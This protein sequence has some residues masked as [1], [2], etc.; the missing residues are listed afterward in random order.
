MGLSIKFGRRAKSDKQRLNMMRRSALFLFVTL[1][2][3]GLA[4]PGLS[5]SLLMKS[6]SSNKV[7]YQKV[8]A[9]NSVEP[10]KRV[11]LNESLASTDL[12]IKTDRTPL[13]EIE[14]LR[15]NNSST[16]LN[17]DG[18]KT[19][20][21]STSQLNFKEGKDWKKISNSLQT[22]STDPVNF[23]EG[24]SNTI[25]NK[26]PRTKS[27]RGDAGII[28][29]TMNPLS[30]GLTLKFENRE[31]VVRPNGANDVYPVKEG[32]NTIVYENAWPNVDLKYELRG[33]IVKELI[34]VKN[35][36]AR[37]SFDFTVSGGKLLNHP[38]RAGEL[39]IEGVDP[40]AFSFSSLTL[41]V[42]ERGVISEPRVSQNPTK[43]G[44]RVTLDDDWV[45]EQAADAFP[46]IIDPSF[47]RY[48]DVGMMYKSDGFSCNQTNCHFNTGM[49]N[50][51][52]GWKSWR[53]E[54]T[55]NYQQAMGKR[56]LQ[57]QIDMPIKQGINRAPETRNLFATWAPCMGFN[58]VGSGPT[59]QGWADADW[60]HID[61]KDLLQ[62]A[63]NAN[64]QNAQFLLRGEEPGYKTYKP[65]YEMNIN[66]VYDTPSPVSQ[67]VEPADKQ[68][69]VD[70]QPTLKGTPITDADGT[71][72]YYFRVTTNNDGNTGA[73][74][75]SGWVYSP[76]WTVPDGVL[77]DGTTYYWK[78]F[79]KDDTQTGTTTESPVRSFKVN[80]RTGKDSTQSYDTVGPVG[81][82]LAT[83]NGSMSQDTHSMTAL[84]GSIGLN[85]NYNTPNKAKKGLLGEY[86]NVPTNYNPTNGAPKDAFG[87]EQ[88]PSVKRREQSVD[89]N[90]GV[91]S[92]DSAIQN[93]G[94]FARWTGQFV[95]P[96]NGTYQ[97]GGNN[98][99][100]MRVW[101]NGTEMYN[102]GCYTGVCYDN[103]KNIQLTAGQ[104]VPMK[105]EYM[106]A[107][108]VAYAR[109]YVKGPVTEQIV[110][111]NWLYANP[112]N[113]SSSY[114]LNGRY[115][116][117]TGDHNIDTA[118][119]DPSRL[120][121]VR[122]DTKLNINYG[123]GGPAQG[124]QADNF[125]TRWT[126]FINVP[127]DGSYTLGVV[128]DDGVRIKL[129]NG[130]GQTPNT[131]L[132]S[133]SYTGMS[134]R[135]G[136][137]AN[138]TAANA[139]PITIDYSEISG[140]ASIQL[141][142]RM[143]NGTESEVPISW[144]TPKA[145]ALP[146]QWSLG[147]DVDGN[148]GYERMRVSA[149][150]AILEDSTGSTH[151]YTYV[152]GGYKPPVNEDG[153][154][155]RN[156]DNTYTL[157]DTDGR[158]YIFNAEGK[159]KSL[160]TPS[161]DRSPASLKYEYSENPS[162][163]TKITDGVTSTRYGTLHY[164]G[165][166]EDGK[167]TVDGGFAAA[168]NG[169]LCA[170]STSDGDVTKLRY[171]NS[172]QLTRVE[173]PG[174]E[175][176]DYSYDALG[177]IV[178]V[179]DSMANDAIAASSTGSTDP[180]NMV[181]NVTYDALSRVSAVKA[182]AASLGAAR[183][184]HTMDYLVGA[185][186]L[187]IAG[188]SE[189]HGFSKRVEYDGL[190]RTTK[191]TD[192]SNLSSFT[193]W[194]PIKDLKRSATDAT[195]LKSTTVYDDNDRA[196]ENYGPAPSAWYDTNWKPLASY[197]NQ[198][199]KTS[200][201]YDEGM[202]G[203]AVNYLEYGTGSKSLIGAS[204][205]VATNISPNPA[206]IARNFGSNPTDL[207]LSTNWGMR[208]TGK[209]KLPTA[210][211]WSFR[212]FSDN[213]VRVWIDDQIVLEDWTDG[214][215]RSHT[216]FS[217]NNTVANSFHRI[218]V[219]YYHTTGD[220]NFALYAT[221]P[222]GTETANVAQ[223]FGPD[224]M[225]A[226]S[227]TAYDAQLGNVT[228]TTT[229]SKPEYGL[230]SK[231]SVDPTGLNLETQ[232]TYEAPGSGFLRQ[233][234][235]TLPGGSTTIYQYYGATE[236][237]VNPCTPSGTPDHQGGRPKGKIEADP[238]GNGP[239]TGRSSE[240]VY[241]KSG[242]IVA[243][244][245]NADPWTCINY[246]SRGRVQS[247][248]V[249]Q[250]SQYQPART[251]ANNYAAGGNPLVTSTTDSTG[252]ITVE[253]DLLGRTV[254]YT[255]TKGNV[256]TNAY[257]LTGLLT[258]RSSPLGTETF[259][260][261]QYD[262]L[263]DQ[264]LDGTT[265]AHIN[266]DQ[267]GRTDNVTYPAAGQ[268][269]VQ[270]SRDVLG[271]TNG[272]SY[273]TVA[274]SGPGPNLVN[275]SSLEQS[276]G[277]PSKPVSWSTDAWGNNTSNLTYENDAHS[278]GKSIKA[279]ITSRTDGDAKWL[280]DSVSVAAGT[281]YTYTD[282]YKSTAWT[283]V[284]AK[285]T[286]Q[287]NS[288]SWVWLGGN[289]ASSSWTQG[290]YSFTTPANAVKVSVTRLID[291]VGW[292][293]LDDVDL[294]QISGGSSA[295]TIAD[296]VAYAV[297]GDVVSGTENGM[298]KSYTYDKG[299]RLTNATI[300]SNSFSYEFGT[301]DA[302]CS[303][304]AGN[305]TNAGKSGNRTKR[306]MN[307]QV[308]TYCYDNAD[309]IIGSSDSAANVFNYDSHGN[310]T[311]INATLKPVYD[312]SDRN[313]G[314]EEYDST[315]NGH[316]VYYVRDAQDRITERRL[317][318][319][320]N[321]NWQDKGALSYGFTGSGD[322]P[323]FTTNGAGVVQEKYLTLPGDVVLTI[324]P[325]QSGS[326]QKTY[327]LPNIHDDVFATTN[328]D[329]VL[330][331]THATGPFGEVLPSQ[332][333]PNNTTSGTT[334]NYVGQHEKITETTFT[335]QL[336]QMGARVYVPNLGRFLSVDPVEG[337]VDNNYV[338]PTDPVNNYDLTGKAKK[339]RVPRS[340]NKFNG[341]SQREL[342]AFE[343]KRIG[344]DFNRS[345]YKS[346]KAKIK[347]TEKFEQKRNVQK[348]VNNNKVSPKSIPKGGSATPPSPS[349]MLIIIVLPPSLMKTLQSGYTESGPA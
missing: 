183:M 139:I 305:N 199:P 27:F 221:P 53:S 241:N 180:D 308:T 219:D 104:V 289:N 39:A 216:N 263:T 245:Y 126:G 77:Q 312:A 29:A 339:G 272:Q 63:V 171:N 295:T 48:N 302:S 176:T 146:D 18:S 318:D 212:I 138:L 32:D 257:S 209:M 89:F 47:Y 274:A 254:K 33:E 264:K 270:Y 224:Y 193:E 206:E 95:A 222:S 234:S 311:Q 83:G 214:A 125:M 87:N 332:L 136:T 278:G 68:V 37:T 188:S 23:F 3:F 130:P 127:T 49:L 236:S 225:L 310:T 197:A 177:R 103:T 215:Q 20:K 337:G 6:L 279:E 239:Q 52:A 73:V 11:A 333:N 298:A 101:V 275:N 61:I 81:I 88:T 322:T 75:N 117:D 155:A 338:Y 317:N 24:I 243:T 320:V 80:L 114:G 349:P 72:Q 168:P 280:F 134:T 42:N 306:T 141:L 154:L 330:T 54:F 294:H 299:G 296:S 213:G 179:R 307:G 347:K 267:F 246:D 186:Q 35:K 223:Y 194:D 325:G 170:F 46:M 291:S 202:T 229:Y 62:N 70:T 112:I 74:I 321:W 107:T 40:G 277:S 345:D 255:D 64:E 149:N 69:T 79:T 28:S 283:N 242:D 341:L 327:S 9:L 240:T 108:S 120:M 228:S 342:K 195:G 300:G 144:L 58:C 118:A 57:A 316:A 344:G 286:L 71:A 287:D 85:F 16:F 124:L 336:I 288:V 189:P 161:D 233:T 217:Y 51:G 260:Y 99:D 252:T 271:R 25:T 196:I 31:I 145:N 158:T 178:T 22:D 303:G 200:T 319:I 249:P 348:R 150:S 226:T 182:P 261:D 250:L 97:F 143:P 109:L 230:V 220:A 10:T 5:L 41:D 343:L 335:N 204:K 121:M 162:R 93:D 82:D 36:N 290:S 4:E 164:A 115:Y 329:G 269:K 148:I 238:D 94:Y 282:Y 78:I 15:T 262:R 26:K 160:T 227:Q 140:P 44:L 218:R 237:R 314:I 251:I 166:N 135:W 92:P 14:N 190:L 86:W 59:A 281:N 301:S 105:V 304:L 102:Q 201:A 98:D 235:K 19:L 198:V 169:M 128:A 253:N 90:W 276:S 129:H 259:V 328:A 111:N 297:S 185:T 96:T 187:H 7:D 1:L 100:L 326:A 315:G 313:R 2:V 12:K 231:T 132:D 13:K 181:T 56:I 232:A 208:M 258:S 157:L 256:T 30:E 211:N 43:N 159:L 340:T 34:V 268:Q 133:W 334:F 147:V 346:A 323:D 207:G 273:T 265:Y 151:E 60:G 173:K 137:S 248:S 192:V 55:F 175:M 244:R 266:Y 210:G 309:R 106:E 285:Y 67:Q 284:L 131:V 293:Q 76:Q 116:T 331:S 174:N 122:Q 65:F 292:V 152:N 153:Q 123:T 66:V 119:A 8:A 17:K 50:D 205:R 84:G 110:S 247:T 172:G 38:T 165:I 184:N 203:L 91:G 156:A 113:Q 163:L 324:R 21:Y 45:K 142:I 191:E 167:C